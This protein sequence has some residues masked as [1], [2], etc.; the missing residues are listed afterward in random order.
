MGK[1]IPLCISLPFIRAID[2]AQNNILH[3]LLF[4]KGEKV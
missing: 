3:F 2:K 1:R 4:I